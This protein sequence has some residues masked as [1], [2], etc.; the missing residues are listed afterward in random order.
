MVRAILS[1]ALLFLALSIGEVK[2][3]VPGAEY[4]VSV[5]SGND[6]GPGSITA[7]FATIGKGTSVLNSGDTLYLR[8]GVYNEIIGGFDVPAGTPDHHTVIAGY[9]G[10]TAILRPTS[11]TAAAGSGLIFLANE[12]ITLQNFTI[13]VINIGG[14]SY[15]GSIGHNTRF[16]GMT[17][18]N[19]GK[20]GLHL[21][22]RNIIVRDSFLNDNGR[23]NASTVDTKGCGIHANG[24]GDP[25]FDISNLLVEK[26]IF[27]GNRACGISVDQNA[28][29]N[30]VTI[31]NNIIRHFGTDS[32]YPQDPKSVTQTGVGIIA[33]HGTNFFIYNNIVYN[34]GHAAQ[35][36]GSDWCFFAWGDSRGS[37]GP[38]SFY[39]NTCDGMNTPTSVGAET[40]NPTHD[41]TFKNNIFSNVTTVFV[42]LSSGA[43][44]S[45]TDYVTNP[46]Y[47]SSSTGDFRLQPGSEGIDAGVNLSSLFTT[48]FAG[49]PR[50]AIFD[51]GAHE[52]LGPT[53]NAIL[54]AVGKIPTR[55][56][57][58]VTVSNA[59]GSATDWVGWFAPGAPGVSS[60][61]WKYLNGT[62]VPPTT[63]ILN[64]TLQFTAP[65]VGGNFEFRLYRNDSVQLGDI[66]AT[67]SFHAFIGRLVVGASSLFKV[68]AARA[69][70]VEGG[71]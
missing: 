60:F 57:L 37:G 66:M 12:Y 71:S 24:N 36:A 45:N 64:T 27:E 50:G 43:N 6:G 17:C 33:A 70:K 10:E 23:I 49:L 68:D 51:I 67:A 69:V 28:A 18:K 25:A 20:T 42:N 32:I 22:G 52:F 56:P 47:V 31:R 30:N 1:L 2:G 29:T 5:G 14:E 44:I 41:V 63:P 4:Y 13:D 38:F 61:E 16:L 35:P 26:N 7:P 54:A 8:G 34:T 58:S 9:P 21:F 40:W 11:G 59:P 48:D 3:A 46:T 65:L 15:C 19:A 62:Q 55:F 53:S 39:N